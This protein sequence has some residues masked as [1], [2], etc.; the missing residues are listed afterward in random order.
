MRPYG[1][2]SAQTLTVQSDVS[3]HAG[4]ESIVVD[5]RSRMRPSEA[6]E[7][8][9]QNTLRQSELRCKMHAAPDVAR[10]W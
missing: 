2:S 3:T 6:V 1:H 8:K 4:E 10:E 5:V 7:R 9:F